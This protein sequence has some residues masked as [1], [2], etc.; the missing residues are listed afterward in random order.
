MAK[1]RR[2]QTNFIG[3]Q[4]D[5][6]FFSRRDLAMWQN[7]ALSLKNN[8]PLIS[9]GVRRRYGFRHL[10]ILSSS[11][12]AVI[13]EFNFD[14]DERY[15]IVFD[16]DGENGTWL[17]YDVD[18]EQFVASGTG[19]WTAAMLPTL[20][21]EQSG[22][23]MFIANKDMPLQVLL[24]TSLTAFSLSAFDFE[25]NAAGTVYSQLYFRFP[26]GGIYI[27]PSAALGSITLTASAALWEETDVGQRWRMSYIVENAALDTM[28]PKWYEFTITAWTDAQTVTVSIHRDLPTWGDLK[29]ATDS[30]AEFNALEYEKMPWWTSTPLDADVIP[31]SSFEEPL[32]TSEFGYPRSIAIH[33]QRLVLAGLKV[34]PSNLYMSKVGAYTNFDDGEGLP[35]ESIQIAAG[36]GVGQEIRHVFS[37]R[38]SIFLTDR[39]VFA[40]PQSDRSPLTPENAQILPQ[41]EY[42]ASTV[43]PVRFDGAVLYV[44]SNGRTVRELRFDDV[45]EQYES[46]ALS[47]IATSMISDDIK[48]I[49][50]LNAIGERPEQLMLAILMNGDV[51]VFHGNR[52]EKIAAWLPWETDGKFLSGVTVSGNELFCIFER[53]IN[54]EQVRTLEKLELDYTMDGATEKDY[55]DYKRLNFDGGTEVPDIGDDIIGS[56]SGATAS[57]VDVTLES[58]TWA[59]SDAVG[60]LVVD[61]N[62]GT[63]ADDEALSV[64][65]PTNRGFNSG[66]DFGFGA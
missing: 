21:A 62:L 48:Q 50:S 26:D 24:R 44:Q 41:E 42:G 4:V 65:S 63:F 8:A 9:G 47:H 52:N 57:I 3:G 43:R 37:D 66:F 59:G 11:A 27:T 15:F 31:T 17:A 40:V 1:V 5:R 39:G 28:V 49:L 46:F 23:T 45:S 19:P 33:T 12:D 22:D 30:D 20:Y 13:A 58:G 32:L 56:V 6:E 14:N 16:H 64:V 36:T 2:S 25:T 35:D 51:A 18:L 60:F 29:G 10:Q 53:E 7:G 34:L 54:G 61:V 55:R 38:Y